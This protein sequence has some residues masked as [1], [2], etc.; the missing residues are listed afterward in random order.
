MVTFYNVNQQQPA[1]R[2]GSWRAWWAA[3]LVAF[4]LMLRKNGSVPLSTKLWR[5]VG[6]ER[7]GQAYCDVYMPFGMSA[8]PGGFD[9][10]TQALVRRFQSRYSG[11]MRC[12]PV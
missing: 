11:T 3:T 2:Q 5:H 9:T 1:E 6:L 7:D 8:A 4:L 12:A 10:I